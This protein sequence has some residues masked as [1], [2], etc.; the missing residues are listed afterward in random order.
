[1]VAKPKS[2][3]S[4][5][6]TKWDSIKNSSKNHQSPLY[7][8]GRKRIELVGVITLPVSFG[9]P[10]NPC[11]EYITFVVVD[12][13]Y[14]YN[15]IFGRSLLNTF[16]D[17]SHSGYHCLKIPATFDVISICGSQQDAEN[18]EKGFML[19]H[20][21]VHVLWEE[22]DHH[23]VEASTEYKKVIEVKGEFKKVPLDPRV[24]NRIMCIGAEASEQ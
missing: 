5:P 1:M 15:A 4:Q 21:N 16:E 23:K 24:P 9:A 13:P 12:M 3:S 14:P 10:K 2:S 11:T 22:P 18:I 6:S 19:G 7:G 8:F 20:K 17:T